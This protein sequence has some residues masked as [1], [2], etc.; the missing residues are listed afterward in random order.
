MLAEGNTHGDIEPDSFFTFAFFV[1]KNTSSHDSYLLKY[2]R[3]LPDVQ[4]RRS[5]LR[6]LNRS[7]EIDLMPLTIL[8]FKLLLSCS[9]S[10]LDLPRAP[11]VSGWFDASGDK[12]LVLFEGET[13]LVN[14]CRILVT[15]F[16]FFF[17][18]DAQA[19]LSKII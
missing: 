11:D 4:E 13:E 18:L 15:K 12:N 10:F 6:P 8:F 17:L 1:A 3:K 5:S 2:L 14:R 19:A 9:F 7:A 16:R